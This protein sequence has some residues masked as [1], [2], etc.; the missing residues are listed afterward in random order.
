MKL[1]IEHSKSKLQIDGPFSICC[2]RETLQGLVDVMQSLLSNDEDKFYH[3]WIQFNETIDNND[4]FV[5]TKSQDQMTNTK[6]INW[7]DSN[8]NKDFALVNSFTNP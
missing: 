2:D 7:N 5:I 4:G 6:P 8:G 3:G 1:I